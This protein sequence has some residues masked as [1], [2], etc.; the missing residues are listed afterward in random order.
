VQVCT[1]L[2]DTD[3]TTVDVHEVQSQTVDMNDD[4][5]DDYAK[6]QYMKVKLS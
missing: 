5:C 4:M 6:L 1:E 3:N 2:N